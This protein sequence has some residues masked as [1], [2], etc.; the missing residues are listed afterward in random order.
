MRE[1]SLKQTKTVSGG[2]PGV[3]LDQALPGVE[4]DQALPGVEL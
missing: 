2:L 4:L 1:L 3:E